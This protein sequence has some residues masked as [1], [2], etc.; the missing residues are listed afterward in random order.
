MKRKITATRIV[1]NALVV[2]NICCLGW[3]VADI[4]F[5]DAEMDHIDKLNDI[6][7]L[8]QGA[9]ILTNGVD[10]VETT[11]GGFAN[12]PDAVPATIAFQTDLRNFAAYIDVPVP[13]I[14][15]RE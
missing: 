6:A 13:A 8:E 7:R 4:K 12:M 15:T 10:Q 5:F 1:L 2:V 11:F 14:P 3:L 9:A